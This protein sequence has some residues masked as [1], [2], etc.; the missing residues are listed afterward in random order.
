MPERGVRRR[1]VRMLGSLPLIAD[2]AR[3][4]QIE[5]SI[6][7]ACPSRSN[8]Q[9]SHAQVAL[10]ILANRLTQPKA[11]VHL[12]DW[13]KKWAVRETFG[14]DPDRLNDD[15]IARCL[16]ALA[17]KIDPIQGAVT[18]AAVREFDLDLSQLHWDLTSV[19]LQGEYPPERQDP[20]H[21]QPR[22]GFGGVDG[23]KQLRVGELV[24][25]DG[26]VPVWH[27]SFDGNQADVGTVVAIM[28]AFRKQVCLPECLVI[29]D[30]KL[31]SAAVMGKLREQQ[32]HFL[33]P[34]PKSPELDGE[35]LCLPEAGWQPLDYVSQRQ[36]KLASAERTQYLGQE[37]TWEW[38]SGVTGEPEQFRRLY[39][40][41]S[42]ERATC[43]KVRAQQL[44]KAAGELTQLGAGVGKGRLKTVEQV[45]ARVAKVLTQR[46]VAPFFRVALRQAEGQLHLAW[47]LDEAAVAAAE[48]LDGYYVLL[49][50]WPKEKAD[51]STLLRRWKGEW[52]IERRFS[53]WKGP[54]KVRPVFVTSN[55]RIAAL[56]LLLQ[57]ALMLYCLLEREARR[58]LARRG[59]QQ[60]RKLLAGQIDAIPTG[61]NILLAFEHLFLF[62][63]E[64]EHGRQY[65]VSEMLPEQEDLWKLLE[66]RMPAWS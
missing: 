7:R 22:Y 14:L 19:V 42:E 29:G 32:L 52:Q 21:P 26:G 3:R 49:C 24:A 28:E 46:R 31:L 54:L 61:E 12:L 50:S 63:E 35:F 16:D 36:A 30:S 10:A 56:M 65:H 38:V 45:E 11:M 60:V 40:I 25:A 43:R 23:C 2:F 55:Q 51:A 41:S 15:R 37:V 53:D 20:N 57:L 6:E 17:S 5:A 1:L 44:V 33:A 48:R 66:C 58:A 27:A 47:E 64:E 39:V 59:Q 8:A 34:L 4:L 62:I 13:A 9:L 18:V